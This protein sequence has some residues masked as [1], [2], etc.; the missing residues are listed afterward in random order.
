MRKI[1][2]FVCISLSLVLFSYCT[3]FNPSATKLYKRALEKHKQYDAAIVPGVPFNEPTWD[4]VMQMRVLW[5]VHLYKK[6]IVKNLIMSG[7][8]VYSPY[9]EG[10]IMKLYAVKMGVPEKHVFVEDKAE[11][12]TE[13][14]WYGY[15]L[16]K[17]KGFENIAMASD[18][19][20]T[21][22]MYRFAKK[23]T[24]GLEFLPVQT[25]TLKTLPHDSI[26]ISYKDYKLKEFVALPQ[27]ES[28][29]QRWRGT[30]GRHINFKE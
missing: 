28:A 27:R 12:S 11:H 13:N 26:T 15:K 1:A 8:A 17:T 9:V 19:F 7:S 4:R 23:R 14:I 20:Q 18:P 3:L 10:Q 5:A 6:G 25:D 29:W 21:N 30:R 24:P 22:L 2:L 16:A